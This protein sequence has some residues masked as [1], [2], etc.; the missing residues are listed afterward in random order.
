M[1]YNPGPGDAPAA[2]YA[3]RMSVCQSCAQ[4]VGTRCKLSHIP[5][6]AIAR[7]AGGSCPLFLWPGDPSPHAATPTAPGAPTR[8]QQ[9]QPLPCVHRGLKLRTAECRA[10]D[11][12]AIAVYGC[13]LHGE[14]TLTRRRG[15]E[16]RA[17]SSCPDRTTRLTASVRF[18]ERPKA[19]PAE[20]AASGRSRRLR[21]VLV[22]PSNGS[23]TGPARGQLFARVL[24]SAGYSAAILPIA[25]DD[26]HL[27]LGQYDMVINHA[28]RLPPETI[29]RHASANPTTT[30][31]NLNHSALAHL[32]STGERYTRHHIRS[33]ALA[34][35]LPNCWYASQEPVADN[36]RIAAGVERCVWLPTPS[37][38]LR[39]RQY[40][41][42]NDPA[43][44][45]FAGRQDPIKNHLVQLVAC[46]LIRR[47]VR[48]LLCMERRDS[49]QETLDQLRLDHEWRGRL[50]H[51]DW[52]RLLQETPDLVLCCSLAES[53]CYVAVEAM[54]VGVPVVASDAIRFAPAA[55]T[56]RSNE[57]A[58]VAAKIEEALRD[59]RT[60]AAEAAELGRAS[61]ERQ[62]T[63]YLNRIC[64]IDTRIF[65]PGGQQ[66]QNT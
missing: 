31:V 65:S 32:E 48:L 21:I 16:S 10:C 57:P 41:R 36:I 29:R 56:A 46:G 55:L 17:C 49:M 25:R 66:D 27:R 59:H 26:Q 53:Y 37:H 64:E 33:L 4:R 1:A 39:P 28:M 51:P 62:R 30:F 61:A 20:I 60:H 52:I 13:D 23:W 14:C 54:Q 19:S 34:R 24:E 5:P 18:T 22:V 58:D 15:V 43:V 44:I 2:T 7:R 40:R 47:R 11:G 3:R 8:A 45:C 12:K 35:D 38:L 6:S 9:E 50:S 42:P 63:E